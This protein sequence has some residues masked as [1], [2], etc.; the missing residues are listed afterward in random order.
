MQKTATPTYYCV[1]F[2]PNCVANCTATP[3]K[4]FPDLFY[5]IKVHVFTPI[6]RRL[7]TY[8][9]DVCQYVSSR[10]FYWDFLMDES[11][12]DLKFELV[13]PLL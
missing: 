9:H 11:E 1:A 3:D 13:R 10:Y 2:A 12:I 7:M 4:L 8:V 5:L 6:S